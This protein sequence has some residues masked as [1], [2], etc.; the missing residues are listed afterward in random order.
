MMLDA[1]VDMMYD[2]IMRTSL[3]L[4]ADVEP[5]LRSLVKKS[6]RSLR[7]VINDLLRQALKMNT[8]KLDAPKPFKVRAKSLALKA[9]I[10]PLKFNQ[11]AD[12]LDAEEII[13]KSKS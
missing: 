10:D 2:V 13:S 6:R 4:D 11:L 12:Q 1:D 8:T 9:G 5:K 3:Y 7:K